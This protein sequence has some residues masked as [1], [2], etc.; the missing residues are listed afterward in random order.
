MKILVISKKDGGESIAPVHI[1]FEETGAEN[2][3]I[4]AIDAEKDVS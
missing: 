4:I 2:N 1:P 3:E